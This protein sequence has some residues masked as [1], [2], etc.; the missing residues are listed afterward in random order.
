[1]SRIFFGTGGL[2]PIW[3]L[4]LYVVMSRAL[5]L[6]L[7]TA[8]NFIADKSDVLQLWIELASEIALLLAALV[9]AAV[10]IPLL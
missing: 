7:S 4:F 3:R 10:F 9:P 1:M 8:L 6:L 5:F 2:R